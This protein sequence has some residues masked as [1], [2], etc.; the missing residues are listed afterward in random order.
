MKILKFEKKLEKLE[1]V[2][3]LDLTNGWKEILEET[4]TLLLANLDVKGFRKGKVPIELASQYLKNSEV[5]DEAVKTGQK[6]IFE[7]LLKEKRDVLF[8]KYRLLQTRVEK[9]S[10]SEFQVFLEWQKLPSAV[11][12]KWKDFK[13]EVE[14]VVVSK[15]DLDDKIM[16]LRKHFAYFVEK[17]FPATQNDYLLINYQAKIDNVLEKTLSGKGFNYQLGQGQFGKSFDLNVQKIKKGEK[18]S[19]AIFL[20]KN[21]FDVK[22]V[23]KEVFFE[24]E[25]IKIQEQKLP[26]PEKELISLLKIDKVKSLQDLRSLLAENVRKTKLTELH[27]QI[28]KMVWPQ[29]LEHTVFEI[30]KNYLIAEVSVMKKRYVDDLK[31][32]DQTLIQNLKE[33]KITE[34]EFDQELETKVRKLLNDYLIVN[35]IADLEKI[36][37][38]DKEIDDY[39]QFLSKSQGKDIAEVKKVYS[40]ALLFNNLLRFQVEQFLVKNTLE[41]NGLKD[42]GFSFPNSNSK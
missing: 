29:L 13:C 35:E 24:V 25:V 38:T 40:K 2:C 14:P 26:E 41:F 3:L 6:K 9:I 33:R 1:F 8:N 28:I 27:Q 4:K 16:D 15:Q 5:L 11:L 12:K 37:V 19:F 34:K 23:G 39:Y 36:I 20:P 21:Y 10:F 32:K 22:F 30:P 17:D 42:G 31:K 7:K 18:S